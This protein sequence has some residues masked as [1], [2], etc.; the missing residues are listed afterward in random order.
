MGGRREVHEDRSLTS[1]K[2]SAWRHMHDGVMCVNRGEKMHKP[3]MA[4]IRPEARAA[5]PA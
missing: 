2:P 3:K 5:Q 4:I 1:R